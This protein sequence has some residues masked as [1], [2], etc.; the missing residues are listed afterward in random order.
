[1]LPFRIAGRY[2]RSKKSHAA[3]NI[4]SYVAIAGVA[5]AAAAM[6][7]VLSVFNGFGDLITA[8]V[9]ASEPDLVVEATS[10]KALRDADSIVTAIESLLPGSRCY[11]AID[12]IGFVINGTRQTPASIRGVEPTSPM[13]DALGSTLVDGEAMVCRDVVG[14]N[15]SIISI[16][17]ANTLLAPP[18]PV[19]YIKIYEPRRTGRIN[20][21]LPMRAFRADS[22]LV[23]GVFRSTDAE[24]DENL[25]I[26][27]IEVARKLLDYTTQASRVEIY[28]PPGS[29]T[30]ADMLAVERALGNEVTVKTRYQMHESS[31]RMV[32]IEKWMTLMMLTFILVIASF[33]V[34]SAMSILI[35]EKRENIAIMRAIGASESFIRRIYVMLTLRIA[36][37]GGLV[38]VAIGVALA[39]CQQYFGWIQL[40]ATDSSVLALDAYPVRVSLTDLVVVVAI[41]VT[42]GAL[43]ALIINYSMKARRRN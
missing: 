24:L 16:G 3:V 13:V 40:A 1:M 19:N 2:L 23:A 11:R 12:E 8:R 25:M 21:S 22:I 18:S 27:P 6:T 20:P 4:I 7:V 39:L 30:A 33:N 15:L 9:A 10:G 41:V 31:Y 28:L 29:D 17:L 38:G 5:L 35:V 26:V 36:V 37:V 43:T 42:I 32:N 14:N 34:L